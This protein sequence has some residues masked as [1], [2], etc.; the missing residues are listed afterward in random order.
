VR[1]D[2]TEDQARTFVEWSKYAGIEYW[3]IDG[4]EITHFYCAKIKK[5]IYPELT[6]EYVTGGVG[7]LNPQWNQDRDSY[8]SGY[9]VGA[10]RWRPM[11]RCME[12]A[13]TF[14]THDA[15]PLLMTPGNP[16]AS[17]AGIRNWC[18]SSP[19]RLRT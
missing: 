13:D 16:S 3:K 1:G 15:S 2:V 8:P 5:A 18:C 14:R 6:L 17:S 9:E 19:D 12:H 11:L 10:G 4:G 7:N